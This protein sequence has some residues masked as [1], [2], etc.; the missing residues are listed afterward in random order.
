[1]E[2]G[3]RSPPFAHRPY[4]LRPRSG[5]R[6]QAGVAAERSEGSL[7]TCEHR[8][9]LKGR[10]EKVVVRAPW[11]P[12]GAMGEGGCPDSGDA[13]ETLVLALGYGVCSTLRE[14]LVVFGSDKSA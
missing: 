8:G 2:L 9:P 4:L 12:E 13:A 11:S 3:A 5:A 7:D 14:E 1:M 6:V 10:W